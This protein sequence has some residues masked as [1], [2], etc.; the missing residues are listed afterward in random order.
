M[1]MAS[2]R[3]AKRHVCLPLSRSKIWNRTS[4]AGMENISRLWACY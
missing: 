2:Y 1:P 3:K 4:H